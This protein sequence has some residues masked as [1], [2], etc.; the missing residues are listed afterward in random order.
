MWTEPSLPKPQVLQ[1]ALTVHTEDLLFL[2]WR[3]RVLKGEGNLW[4]GGDLR[5]CK[6]ASLEG[7]P[8]NTSWMSDW[9][10]PE[11]YK[12]CHK[13]NGM[14]HQSIPLSPNK[15]FHVLEDVW[16]ESCYLFWVSKIAI[17][18]FFSIQQKIESRQHLQS[19]YQLNNGL[20]LETFRRNNVEKGSGLSV[21]VWNIKQ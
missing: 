1:N 8:G 2:G 12:E 6:D 13:G 21:S 20:R 15:L 7:E 17:S 18:M 9:L 19:G 16:I 4:D 10:I 11:F 14:D 5:V 3:E